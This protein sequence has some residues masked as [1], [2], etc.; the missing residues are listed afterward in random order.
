MAR[1]T[2]KVTPKTPGSRYVLK[3]PDVIKL[4]R[5]TY[6]DNDRP[7]DTKVKEQTEQR[8]RTVI[9]VYKEGKALAPLRRH[10]RET[11]ELLSFLSGI[12]KPNRA[13]YATKLRRG[14]VRRW[15]AT[16][17]AAAARKAGN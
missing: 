11:G 2:I 6:V 15:K 12:G 9:Y 4:I 8:A 7:A 10:E 13:K 1:M 3:H 14:R 16:Q 17:K 5:E